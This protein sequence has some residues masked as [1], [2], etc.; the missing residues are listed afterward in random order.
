MFRVVD[1]SLYYILILLTSLISVLCVSKL[2]SSKI[3]AIDVHKPNKVEI[4]KIGGLCLL[5]SSLISILL[6]YFLNV[7][8]LELLLIIQLPAIIVGIVGLLD[9][10]YDIKPIF[11][12]LTCILTSIVLVVLVTPTDSFLIVGSVRNVFFLDSLSCILM[13]IMFNA[14]NML[15]VMNGVV[16]GACLIIFTT[17]L[18]LSIFYGNIDNLKIYLLLLCQIIPLFLFNKY[19]ARVFLGN[20]GSYMLGVYIGI[21][22]CYCGMFVETLLACLPF[23]INGLLILASTRGRVFIGG[24]KYA[25]RPI[26]CNGGILYPNPDKN[27]TLSL[28]RI[29]VIYGSNTEPKVVKRIL[30]LFLISCILTL[31]IVFIYR[32][33]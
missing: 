22:A 30:T 28:A 19:P 16:S 33:I 10:L 14:V 12:I 9:D 4:P 3:L 23:I 6:D 7:I 31:I 25:S 15:D 26:I 8:K 17:M 2:R 18:I 32:L 1:L 27:A 21:T 11:R 5:A 24:R 29:F 13:I 20:V